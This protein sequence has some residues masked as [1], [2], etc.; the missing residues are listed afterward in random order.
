VTAETFAFRCP[1]CDKQGRAPLAAKGKVSSCS[2]CNEV[3]RLSPPVQPPAPGAA[4]E[5]QVPN[6]V[7]FTS[8]GNSSG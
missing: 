5:G 7:L 8:A 2:R 3:F 6:S 4:R 1:A